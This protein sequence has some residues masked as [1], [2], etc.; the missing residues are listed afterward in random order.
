M[1]ILQELGHLKIP[2]KDIKQATNYFSGENIIGY[3]AYGKIYKG[4]LLRPEGL[5]MIAAKLV[6][7][8]DFEGIDHFLSEI[9]ILAS[10]KHENIVSLIG[11]CDE[12]DE[13]IL[14]QEFVT[15]GSL[16]QYLSSSNL[17]WLKRLQICLGAA[18]GLSYLHNGLK[19]WRS[20]TRIPGGAK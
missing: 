15:Y 5:T 11:F 9:K 17:T 10:Y 19:Q 7:Q 20:L 13:K 8:M 6:D 1:S 3:G 12:N 16:D 14:V 4:E 18:R 2:L